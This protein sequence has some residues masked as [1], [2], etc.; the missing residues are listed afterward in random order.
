MIRWRV[1]LV[2]AKGAGDGVRRWK[3][4]VTFAGAIGFL[5]L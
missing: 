5:R 2:I 3:W 1:A 4:I